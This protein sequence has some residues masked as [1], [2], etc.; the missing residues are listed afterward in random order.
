MKQTP[1]RLIR[2]YDI[3]A[4]ESEQARTYY[5]Y[6]SDKLGSTT[7]IYESQ[8]LC[9]YYEYNAFGN[10]VISE[11]QFKNRFKYTG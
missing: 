10:L 7:H 4:S 5:H 8:P 11:E 9:N 2:G 3:I 6:A 1:F